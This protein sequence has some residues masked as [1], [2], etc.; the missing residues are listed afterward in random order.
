MG[1]ESARRSP[2]Q[3]QLKPMAVPLPTGRSPREHSSP[4]VLKT[5]VYPETQVMPCDPEE[6][7]PISTRSSAGVPK[8]PM[9][10]LTRFKM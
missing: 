6:K 2:A 4:E 10:G 3:S 1:C 7:P 9:A 5:N 8:A